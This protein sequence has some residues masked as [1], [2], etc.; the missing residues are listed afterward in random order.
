MTDIDVGQK[1]MQWQQCPHTSPLLCSMDPDH[2]PMQWDERGFIYCTEETCGFIRY[3]INPQV[4]AMV[5]GKR[6]HGCYYEGIH[7]DL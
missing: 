2:P 3:D 6:H 1:V 7:H 4:T 5:H